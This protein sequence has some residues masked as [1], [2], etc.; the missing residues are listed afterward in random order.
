MGL[1]MGAKTFA[2]LVKDRLSAGDIRLDQIK[3]DQNGRGFDVFN[4]HGV[5]FAQSR[6]SLTDRMAKGP[7]APTW[8]LGSS[9]RFTAPP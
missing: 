2:K 7:M 9:N 3:V 6:S 8:A 1:D 5:S 4:P